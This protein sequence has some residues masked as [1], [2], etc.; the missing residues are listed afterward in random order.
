MTSIKKRS[1]SLLF[2]SSFLLLL[3]LLLLSLLLVA[4][5]AVRAGVAKPLAASI[6]MLATPIA[7]VWFSRRF[8]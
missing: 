6:N 1:T 3:L 2:L 7:R 8:I 5:N 4:A